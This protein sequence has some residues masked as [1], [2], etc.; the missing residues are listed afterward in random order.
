MAAEDKARYK[1]EMESYVPPTE[2]TV[3]VAP[4]TSSLEKA[5]IP[6]SSKKRKRDSNK[7]SEAAPF[8]RKHYGTAT[9]GIREVG[10]TA[11]KSLIAREPPCTR[12]HLVCYA[13]LKS[14]QTHSHG[15]YVKTCTPSLDT[16]RT[17]APCEMHDHHPVVNTLVCFAFGPSKYL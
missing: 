9:I 11:C 1:Q 10:V 14:T 2:E 6:A 8:G 15:C 5:K 7:T 13:K 16:A 12:T 4:A 17:D 3:E